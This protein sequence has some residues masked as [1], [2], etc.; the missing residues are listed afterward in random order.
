MQDR[1]RDLRRALHHYLC[2]S[3][4][5]RSAAAARSILVVVRSPV[6]LRN[7]PAAVARSRDSGHTVVAVGS[8]GRSSFEVEEL[9]SQIGCGRH[10]EGIEG[11]RICRPWCD[12]C[13]AATTVV[14]ENSSVGLGGA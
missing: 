6:L 14:V 5:P 4:R 13:E 10:R 12:S 3:R 7:S 1:Q 8:S 11:L 2:P 9:G